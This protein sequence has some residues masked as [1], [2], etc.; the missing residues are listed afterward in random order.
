MPFSARALTR[1]NDWIQGV[2]RSGALPQS[3][4]LNGQCFFE[5]W[6]AANCEELSLP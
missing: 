2:R 4:V 6:Q 5:R 1:R 3:C